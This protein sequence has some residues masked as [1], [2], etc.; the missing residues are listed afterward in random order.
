MF[1]YHHTMYYYDGPIWLMMMTMI[2]YRFN[3]MKNDYHPDYRFRVQTNE[4]E[5]CLNTLTNVLSQ[6]FCGITG[7]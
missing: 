1:H 7:S 3:I 4:L 2:I 5:F 6:H